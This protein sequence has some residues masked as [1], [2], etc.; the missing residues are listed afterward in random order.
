MPRK[1]RSYLPNVPV[2]IVQRGPFNLRNDPYFVPDL[3]R[4]EVL[5]WGKAGSREVIL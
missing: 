5:V 3:R 4:Y 1:Q 2:N